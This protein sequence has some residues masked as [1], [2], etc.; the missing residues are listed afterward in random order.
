MKYD[1]E[2]VERIAQSTK[3]LDKACKNLGIAMNKAWRAICDEY[4]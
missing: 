4:V 2:K 1:K 3:R